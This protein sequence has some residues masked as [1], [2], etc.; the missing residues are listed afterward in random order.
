MIIK[1]T[2]VVAVFR[3]KVLSLA[4]LTCPDDDFDKFVIQSHKL[5]NSDIL[6]SYL[7]WKVIRRPL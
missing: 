1:I 7:L 2:K 4:L 6:Y 5:M 3:V